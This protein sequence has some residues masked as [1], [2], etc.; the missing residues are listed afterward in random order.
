MSKRQSKAI[1]ILLSVFWVLIVVLGILLVAFRFE[2]YGF[3]G[4]LALGLG[5]LMLIVFTVIH[6]PKRIQVKSFVRRIDRWAMGL[7][8]FAVVLFLAYSIVQGF[9]RFGLIGSG[10]LLLFLVVFLRILR[11]YVREVLLGRRPGKRRASPRGKT[12][13]GDLSRH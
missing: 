8:L 12:D 5:V 6:L 3:G 10:V 2:E 1:F 7:L 11:D 4:L 13:Q 9:H